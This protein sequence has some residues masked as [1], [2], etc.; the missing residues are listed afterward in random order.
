MKRNICFYGIF[1]TLTLMIAACSSSPGSGSAGGSSSKDYV[2]AMILVPAGSFQYDS[3]AADVCTIAAAFHMS[4]YDITGAQFANVTGI[5]DP[6]AFSEVNHPVERLT[7]YQAIFFCNKLSILEGLTPAYS[8]G[9]STDPSAWGPIPEAGTDSQ[10]WDVVQVNWSANGFRLPTEMEYM[11]AA[12]GATSG[13][14]YTSGTYTTGYNKAFAGSTG[15]NSINNYAM[16]SDFIPSPKTTTN[17]GLLDP[18]ELG[19]YDMSGNVAQWCW[20]AWDGST[21]YNNG[22]KGAL[23]DPVGF[24]GAGYSGQAWASAGGR[25]MR[26]GCWDDDASYATVAIRVN[27]IP[28]DGGVNVGF[29]VVRQ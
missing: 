13:Y 29:R 4:K 20:D 28:Y 1:V 11:W 26:G 15:A 18:N 12:M 25:V 23:T 27:G 7:W 17:V 19:L 16:T 8:I 5:A 6:S 21:A 3:T 10:A 9:G 2:S 14:G 22:N 24:S